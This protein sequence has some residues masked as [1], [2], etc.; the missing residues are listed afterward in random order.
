MED[1]NNLAK[2]NGN[3]YVLIV[4]GKMGHGKS[5]FCKMLVSDQNKGN[6]KV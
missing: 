6:I 5:S 3:N 2:K 4:V 1:G